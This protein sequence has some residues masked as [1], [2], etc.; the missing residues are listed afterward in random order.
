MKARSTRENPRLVKIHRSYSVEEVGRLFGRHKNSVLRWLKTGLPA[1]DGRKPYLIRGRDLADFLER[2]RVSRK[3]PCGTSEMF[4][5][6]CRAPRAPVALCAFYEPQT[7]L[8]GNLKAT[9]GTCGSAMNR[10]T[11]AAKLARFLGHLSLAMPEALQH[12][13]Q[14]PD[15]TLN[16]ELQHGGRDA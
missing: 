9:C 13:V 2:R 15:P 1:I 12:I 10:R 14:S 5:L 3:R 16:C 7:P 11:S 6:R 8:L 4:C